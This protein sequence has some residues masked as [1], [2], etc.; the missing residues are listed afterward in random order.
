VEQGDRLKKFSNY[1]LKTK[2]KEVVDQIIEQIKNL[3]HDVSDEF[4]R[5]EKIIKE[6]IVELNQRNTSGVINKK[7]QK[8]L[9]GIL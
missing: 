6:I 7:K 1:Y 4:G 3:K 9:L 8:K 5:I 2:S